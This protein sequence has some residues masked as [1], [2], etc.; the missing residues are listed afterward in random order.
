M[1]FWVSAG[2]PRADVPDVVGLSSSEAG[3]E[4]EAAGFT[5]SVDVVWGWGEYP[6]T[7]VEQDPA[8][9][10]RAEQRHRGDDQR[11]GVLSLAES[12]LRSVPRPAAFSRPP[13][14]M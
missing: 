5:V 7:V 1:T 3:A 2:L 12:A 13:P 8:A 10:T 9:G 4:L 14:S 11:R 6:D